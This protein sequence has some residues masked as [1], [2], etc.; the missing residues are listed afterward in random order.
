LE[1]SRAKFKNTRIK[2]AA[3][4][5]APVKNAEDGNEDKDY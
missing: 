2:T 5:V 3:V 4:E 1:N